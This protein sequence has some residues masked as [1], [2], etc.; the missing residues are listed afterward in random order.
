MRDNPDMTEEEADEEL[1]EI[2]TETGT[3]ANIFKNVKTQANSI[4][5]NALNE[6]TDQ[7]PIQE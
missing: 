7:S 2:K 3:N 6:R 4:I 5:G 1:A